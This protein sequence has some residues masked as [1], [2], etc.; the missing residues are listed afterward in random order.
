MIKRLAL[1]LTLA[2]LTAQTMFAA[3]LPSQVT[4]RLPWDK[5][6]SWAVNALCTYLG[7]GCN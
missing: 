3:S 4:D 2:L 7:I 6:P 1:G 5:L